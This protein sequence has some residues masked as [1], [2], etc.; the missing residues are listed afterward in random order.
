MV[1][2]IEDGGVG[3]DLAKVV[4]A[5]RRA[6]PD[7]VALEEAMG[8]TGRIA[9]ALGWRHASA[10]TQILSRYP[11]ID[12][13]GGEGVFVFVELRPGRV[14]AVANVH[15]P[16]DP[17]GLDALVRGGSP[18]D[19]LDLERRVRLPM[20][21]RALAVLRRSTEAEVPVILLGDFNA[22]SHLDWTTASVGSR[23]QVRTA[24]DWPV[25]RAIEAA[26]FRDTW[27]EI[28]PDPVAEPGLTWWAARPAI[29]AGDPRPGDPQERIDIIYARGPAAIRNSQVVGE[30]GR[31]GIEIGVTPWPSDHR[32]VVSTLLLSLAPM[33][34]LV[35][36]GQRLVAAGDPLE[37]T[38]RRPGEVGEQ[39][40]IEPDGPIRSLEGTG[41]AGT[42]Q[43]STA[44]LTAGWYAAVLRSRGGG[45][46][47]QA[48]FVIRAPG[49]QVELRTARPVYRVGGPIEVAWAGGPGN[50]WDWIAVFGRTERTHH[51]ALIWEHTDARI[52]GTVR[53][54]AASAV[55]DQSP[56]GGRWPLPPGD[57]EVAY[58]LDDSDERVAEAPLTIVA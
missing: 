13:P 50:R 19:V 51:E 49:A 31:P 55:V 54:D 44:G 32:A 1:F 21:E 3:V 9:N 30:E 28:H 7:I 26:G 37:V 2:N 57:Y 25:S 24:I 15:L 22:P 27:R 46:V 52:D 36:V 20:V 53:L 23:T 56:A 12:P 47:S 34:V 35:A 6:D 29:G 18:A 14:A 42:L 11:I 16:S 17:Y 40:S 45:I 39:L 43:L 41:Q 33:P 48:R 8:N 5:I 58:L 10:R 38:W 4:E